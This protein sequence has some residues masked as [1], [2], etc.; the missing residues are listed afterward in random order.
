M[1]AAS[2]KQNPAPHR[3]LDRALVWLRRDLRCY[4]HAALH[5]A[6]RSARQVWCVFVFDR[7]LLAT[8]EEGLRRFARLCVRKGVTTAADLGNALS[9]DAV[10]RIFERIISETRAVQTG[11]L[12]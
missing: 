9:P 1:P 2:S 12:A 6:L 11:E 3:T 8:D 4:D 5:Q 10:A 7:D